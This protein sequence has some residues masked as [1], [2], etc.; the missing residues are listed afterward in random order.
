MTVGTWIS[1][2]TIILVIVATT[3]VIVVLVG[4]ARKSQ[5]T[6]QLSTTSFQEDSETVSDEK[7]AVVG[8]TYPVEKG[9]N[10]QVRVDEIN[11][12]EGEIYGALL[13]QL[14]AGC[15]IRSIQQLSEDDYTRFCIV[16]IKGDIWKTLTLFYWDD[17]LPEFDNGEL[18]IQE[19]EV[20]V[21][22][23]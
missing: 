15:E 18:S 14:P 8:Q 13:V 5:V 2:I 3:L 1:P 20:T 9:S 10:I 4:L 6:G 16:Y 17:E 11:E 23:V 19:A 12:D 22:P 21:A 7:N